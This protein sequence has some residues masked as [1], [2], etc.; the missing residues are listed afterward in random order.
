M[1][2][3][4]HELTHG[5]VVRVER[6]EQRRVR[7][8]RIRRGRCERRYPKVSVRFEWPEPQKRERQGREAFEG[9]GL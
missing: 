4:D 3:N 5:G 9:G 2:R 6:L 8:G 7:K 1:I